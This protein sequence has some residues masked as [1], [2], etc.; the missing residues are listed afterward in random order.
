[1]FMECKSYEE[2]ILKHK[3]NPNLYESIRP[4]IYRHIRVNSSIFLKKA[5]AGK[6][7]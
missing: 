4:D 7:F 5:Q 3:I 6:E 2:S 1:M